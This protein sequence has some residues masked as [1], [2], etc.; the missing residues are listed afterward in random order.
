MAGIHE[1]PDTSIP[2]QVHDARIRL[3]HTGHRRGTGTGARRLNTF[4]IG[5]A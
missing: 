5:Q 3:I 2:K 4:T 1:K